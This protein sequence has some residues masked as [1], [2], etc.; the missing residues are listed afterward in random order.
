MNNLPAHKTA[1][2]VTSQ[3]DKAIITAWENEVSKWLTD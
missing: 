3:D 1:D 2:Q